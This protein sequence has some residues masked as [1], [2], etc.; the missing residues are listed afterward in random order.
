MKVTF[1][2]KNPKSQAKTAIQALVS[3]NYNRLVVGT[4]TSVPSQYWDKSKYRVK[5][6]SSFPQYVE[7]NHNLNTIQDRI[8]RAYYKLY[9]N[10]EEVPGR[11]LLRKAI[12]I[13]L[14]RAEKKKTDF[15]SLFVTFIHQKKLEGIN[16]INVRKYEYTLDKLRDFCQ[17]KKLDLT[18]E[19]ITLEF[20]FDFLEYL[21][22]KYQFK[23]NTQGD[24]IRN[25]KA[26]LNDATANGYNTNMMFKSKR[27][28]KPTEEVH[29]IYLNMEEINELENLNL[30]NIPRLERVR[31]QF[32]VGCYTGLRFG[33]LSKLNKKHIDT[34]LI[35]IT[36][37]KTRNPISIPLLPTVKKVLERYDGDLPKAISADKTR[38]YLKEV[39]AMCPML[40]KKEEI[41]EE[42]GE[43]KNIK[44]VPKYKLVGTHTARR[45]FATNMYK[46]GIDIT[47]IRQ[48][49]GH[50]AEKAFFKYIK[51]SP[52]E[53]AENLKKQFEKKLILK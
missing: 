39:C 26:F 23:V 34:D 21:D 36:P 3:W 17:E 44:H 5:S 7:I 33:D 13:E 14:G 38:K 45:S 15:E 16:P 6:A 8:E 48:I 25:L 37:G 27:F 51:L 12:E 29:N 19:N 4:K 2:L 41:K 11:E 20:Y 53:H 46:L 22:R 28:K 9:I 42:R 49:T 10:S 43:Y 30:S 50:K 24:Y 32:L 47:T 18:F 1:R 35:R 52:D 40:N 31:D